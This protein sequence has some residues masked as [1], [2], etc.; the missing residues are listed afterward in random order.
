[1]TRLRRNSSRAMIASTAPQLIP[2]SFMRERFRGSE[3]AG[4]GR[5]EPV[6][7]PIGVAEELVEILG[8]QAPVDRPLDVA[9]IEQR[10]PQDAQRRF[11]TAAHRPPELFL[12]CL[13]EEERRVRR[14]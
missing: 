9:G 11:P 12:V 10:Q 3:F 6:L 14:P 1:M 2:W 4:D 13:R 8:G 5:A 7:P